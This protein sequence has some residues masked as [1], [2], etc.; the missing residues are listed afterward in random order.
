MPLLLAASAAGLAAAGP[1]NAQERPQLRGAISGDEADA[2]QL[3]DQTTADAGVLAEPPVYVP[4]S[5]GALPDPSPL[6][7]TDGQ[8]DASSGEVTPAEAA[9]PENTAAEAD[10]TPTGTVRAATIDFGKQPPAQR[11]R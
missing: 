6:G 1:A 4:V 2:A 10:Q 3:G 11:R 8:E 9:Q 7:V 5:P